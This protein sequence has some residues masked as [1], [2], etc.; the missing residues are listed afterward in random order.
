MLI[1]ALADP[2]E[3][4]AVA[5]RVPARHEAE[6]GRHVSSVFEVSS[7]A[8]RGHHGR[9]RLWADPSDPGNPLAG[10]VLAE[11]P[12][13]PAVEFANARVDLVEK[14]KK[15]SEDLAAGQQSPGSFCAPA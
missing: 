5:A 9:G 4:T 10:I 8:D 14:R 2:H 15:A 1:A 12:I 3:D 7:F 6:P 13:D 11:N